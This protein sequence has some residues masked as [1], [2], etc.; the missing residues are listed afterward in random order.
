M[1]ARGSVNNTNSISSSHQ[2]SAKGERRE[3]AYA[4]ETNLSIKHKSMIIANALTLSYGENNTPIHD[5]N[6]EFKSGVYAVTG[7]S[8]IGKSTLLK[9]LAGLIAPAEGEV[10]SN[11]KRI[12]MVF[13]E[14]RLIMSYTPEQNLGLI[15]KDKDMIAE[16]LK[17]V[18]LSEVAKKRVSKLSGGQQRRVALARALLYGGDCVILDEPFEGLDEELKRRIASIFS[19]IFPLIIISTHDV[20]DANLLTASEPVRI[21]L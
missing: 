21:T 19:E 9:G 5:F 15:S 7:K 8:G 20:N 14:S 10:I 6:Y 2:Q 12:S 16:I 11:C 13:Q 18:G 3:Q 1:K 17:K 4:E